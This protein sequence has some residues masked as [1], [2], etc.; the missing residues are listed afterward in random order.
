MAIKIKGEEWKKRKDRK[1]CRYK[2]WIGN[3][4]CKNDEEQRKK[5]KGDM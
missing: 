3:E 1:I 4:K 2:K 5:F